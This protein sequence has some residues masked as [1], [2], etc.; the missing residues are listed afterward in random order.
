MSEY[1]VEKS[2]AINAPIQELWRQIL[3]VGS[4][5]SWKSFI[6]A[7]KAP[8]DEFKVGTT[9]NMSIRVKG[10]ISF[11]TPVRVTCHEPP[12]KVAWTGGLPGLTMSVHTFELRE[13]DGK[14]VVTSREEFTGVLV[15]LMLLLLTPRDMEKLH[16]DWL[17]AIKERVGA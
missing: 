16:D 14:T 9:F 2:L 8:T 10:P 1:K 17:I 3:D 12:H 4:W 6:T 7:T 13:E 5:P 11:P 15:R